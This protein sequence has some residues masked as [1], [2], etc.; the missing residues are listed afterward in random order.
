MLKNNRTDQSARSAADSYLASV[1]AEC[2]R[3]AVASGTDDHQAAST[4]PGVDA[5][6]KR[7]RRSNGEDETGAAEER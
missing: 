5:V 6:G 1:L 3:S 2:I 7:D 4:L